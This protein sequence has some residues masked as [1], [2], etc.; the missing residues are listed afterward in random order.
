MVRCN[1]PW[2][3]PGALARG[4]R[5][6]G[7]RDHSRMTDP[8]GDRLDT[9]GEAGSASPMVRAPLYDLTHDAIPAGVALWVNLVC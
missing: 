2:L 4:L 9:A 1:P 7:R 5:P 3:A 6:Q 8:I